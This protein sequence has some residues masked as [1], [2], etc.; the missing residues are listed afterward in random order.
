MHWLSHFFGLDNLAGPFYGFWSGVGGDTT[1]F[2]LPATAYVLWR[3]H[4]CHVDRCPRIGRHPVRG[5]EWVLCR[6]HH[7]DDKLTH[8][9][10]MAH[11]Q[12]E[13]DIN[14]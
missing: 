11:A 9:D 7:P 1:A 8:A 12:K 3:R 5:T 2:G 10:V 14:G 13:A 6:K 4:N